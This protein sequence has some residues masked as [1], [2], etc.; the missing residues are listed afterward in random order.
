MVQLAR[1]SGNPKLVREGKWE[2]TSINHRTGPPKSANDQEAARFFFLFFFLGSPGIFM[3]LKVSPIALPQTVAA[4]HSLVGLA[5]MCTSIGSF[6]SRSRAEPLLEPGGKLLL[7]GR[8]T[9]KVRLVLLGLGAG[10][11]DWVLERDGKPPPSHHS[12]R[13]CKPPIRG[14]RT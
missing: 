6:V 9:Q 1:L 3:G 8:V 4:F 14:R 11:L 12:P 5:A 2:S 10:D 13:A 7:A